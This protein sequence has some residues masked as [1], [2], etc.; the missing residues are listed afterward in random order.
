MSGRPRRVLRALLAG[1]AGMIALWLICVVAVVITGRSDEHPES[2]A[3]VILGAAQYVGR[4]SPVLQA[5]LDHG[6][7]LWRKRAAPT[8]IVTG[9]IGTG[10][11]TSEAEVGRRYL[12][13]AGIPDS[14]ILLERAGRT[15]GQSLRAVA[16]MLRER[17]MHSA[18]L[19]SD[20]FHSLRLKI[21][22]A[23]NGFAGTTSPTRTSPISRNA[24][25]QWRY[26]LG[27]ALRLPVA[28]L[29]P[30]R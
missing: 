29:F 28:A 5:R 17:R 14:A 22:A 11:T 23:R 26:V 25:T 13:A 4:P 30:G 2:D 18:I 10:D 9:G 21:L 24:R 8:I 16:G 15:T 1:I 7:A 27:E 6:A 3:I 20:P 19:V 12:L